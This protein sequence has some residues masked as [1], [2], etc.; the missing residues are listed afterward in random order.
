MSALSYIIDPGGAYDRPGINLQV[1]PDGDNAL[2]AESLGIN[3]QRLANNE[4]APADYDFRYKFS[5]DATMDS[6]KFH[7]L[8]GLL[9][10]LQENANNLG[11]W[12]VVLYN[13]AE[14]F[15]EIGQSR[16]RYKVPSTAVITQEDLGDGFYFWQY[17]VAI[18]GSL[19][20]TK[21]QK[22]GG[23]FKVNLQFSEGTFLGSNLE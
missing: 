22:Y 5:F 23:H 7:K 8:N 4:L 19:K 13:L 21:S 20:I 12:E 3:F 9:N 10:L 15:S 6:L 1:F 16:S 17:W 2:G 18:Q 11:Q 14:P